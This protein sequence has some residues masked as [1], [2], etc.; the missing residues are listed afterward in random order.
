M[1]NYNYFQPLT[2]ETGKAMTNQDYKDFIIP[3]IKI[4]YDIKKPNENFNSIFELTTQWSVNHFDSINVH[5]GLY[6]PILSRNF[7]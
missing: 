4:F 2:V 5:F 3:Q 6:H 7:N 1:L